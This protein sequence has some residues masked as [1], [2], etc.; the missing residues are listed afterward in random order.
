MNRRGFFG[1][2]GAWIAGLGGLFGRRPSLA[3]GPPAPV[4][5][6]W[7]DVAEARA[8]INRKLSERVK[9]AEADLRQTRAAFYELEEKTSNSQHA[10]KLAELA[11]QRNTEMLTEATKRIPGVVNAT[12]GREVFPV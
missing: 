9:D 8:D 12:V 1:L 2:V 10:A 11:F 5:R 6:T 7:R 3:A 4:S